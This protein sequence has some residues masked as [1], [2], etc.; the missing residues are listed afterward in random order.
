MYLGHFK[1]LG[2][3]YSFYRFEGFF[4]FFQGYFG[5]FL[6]SGDILVIFYV[7]GSILVIFWFQ[8]YF[9]YFLGFRDISVIF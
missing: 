6:G 5:N 8:E 7:Y 3:F 9:C 1:G 4:F 2:V